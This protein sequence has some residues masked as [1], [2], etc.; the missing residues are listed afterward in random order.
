MGGRS[1]IDSVTNLATLDSLNDSN[2]MPWLN[3][4]GAASLD[5]WG[6]FVHE[7][8]H[9]WCFDSPVGLSIALLAMRSRQL[10]LRDADSVGERLNTDILHTLITLTT[11]REVL[12]PIAEG[13]A[14][15]G[16]FDA[17]P[18]PFVDQ[19]TPVYD[20]MM[21]CFS[22]ATPVLLESELSTPI[23]AT[24]AVLGRIRLAPQ[25]VDRKASVLL[26]PLSA[27][28]NPYLAGY[29]SVKALRR[30]IAAVEPG[31]LTDS[32]TFFRVLQRYIYADW[33]LVKLLLGPTDE[34]GRTA[35][36][37]CNHVSG[38]LAQFAEVPSGDLHTLIDRTINGGP[39]PDIA[40]WD[41]TSETR[42]A[43]VEA[44]RRGLREAES[45][46]T[47][48]AAQRSFGKWVSAVLFRRGLL[49]LAS[50]QAELHSGCIYYQGVRVLELAADDFVNDMRPDAGPVDLEVVFSQHPDQ[51]GRAAVVTRD[52]D[53]L[54]CVPLGGSTNDDAA[55]RERIRRIYVSGSALLKEEHE[56]RG[57]ID[58]VVE[59][60]PLSRELD[61]YLPQIAAATDVIY[62]A[63][64]GSDTL[65]RALQQALGETGLAAVLPTARLL[66]MTAILG[67]AAS[68]DPSDTSCD[69]ALRQHGLSLAEAAATLQDAYKA[70]RFP[71]A[72]LFVEGTV[73]GAI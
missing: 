66:R 17:T 33:K 68:D 59:A 18:D 51:W 52:D 36:N 2:P 15:F 27:S 23:A 20:A 29:L 41:D 9:H 8:T 53:I 1:W 48:D 62:S 56:T 4:D 71:D 39:A 55:V 37:L 42:E 43:G 65:P 72:P 32:M 58:G 34:A 44:L 28:A 25:T 31:L 47:L 22:H 63:I 70:H 45:L 40:A 61:W 7:A 26:S 19:S 11:A 50:G 3:E 73:V 46:A 21:D 67:L 35:E 5:Q 16:E 64:V 54:A 12:R 14:Q 69:A 49:N 60:S 57:L 6:P 10:I 13:L 24:K 38:R 30:Q